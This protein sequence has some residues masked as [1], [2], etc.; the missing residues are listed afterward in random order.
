MASNLPPEI[1]WH[2]KPAQLYLSCAHIY[3]CTFSSLA[4]LPCPHFYASRCINIKCRPPINEPAS[5][6]KPESSLL[7]CGSVRLPAD[8]S[9]AESGT[10]PCPGHLH[11][12]YSTL[13]STRAAGAELLSMVLA[14]GGDGLGGSTAPCSTDRDFDLRLIRW[15]KHEEHIG[16][17]RTESRD[18]AGRYATNVDS[19][20]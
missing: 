12:G 11:V 1:R 5:S 13:P 17:T 4:Y 19:S 15:K 9:Y 3:T 8:P 14:L 16:G 10:R 18:I 6:F 2:E 20:L 7:V